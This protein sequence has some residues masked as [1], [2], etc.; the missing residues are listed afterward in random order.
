FGESLW[1][2]VALACG[3]GCGFVVDAECGGEGDSLRW[4]AGGLSAEGESECAGVF[5]GGGAAEIA[6]GAESGGVSGGEGE[7]PG[8]RRWAGWDVD[9][10]CEWGGGG[11]ALD[12]AVF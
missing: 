3:A 6:G 1:R 11:G 2:V 10:E 4:D 9:C 5:A 12:G 7:G 8:G